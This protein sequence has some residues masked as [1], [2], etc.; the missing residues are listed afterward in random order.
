MQICVPSCPSRSRLA[1]WRW[2]M[3]R[4][5]DPRKSLPAAYL[6]ASQESPADDPRLIARRLRTTPAALFGLLGHLEVTIEKLGRQRF[7][8]RLD[9]MD[10]VPGEAGTPLP[11]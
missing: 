4:R 11:P 8:Y 10:R 6:P 7:S 3:S 1:S 2:S 9:P 5:D